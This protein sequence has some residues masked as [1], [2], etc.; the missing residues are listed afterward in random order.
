MWLIL[1]GV[2]VHVVSNTM[3]FMRKTM[4]GHMLLQ[5]LV[6]MGA[7]LAQSSPAAPGELKVGPPGGLVEPAAF[8]STEGPTDCRMESG[9]FVR[10]KGILNIRYFC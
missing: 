1:G 2:G 6:R 8:P 5:C 9:L 7:M 10:I 4:M 3:V